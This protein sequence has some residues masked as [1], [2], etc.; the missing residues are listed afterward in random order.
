MISFLVALAVLIGGYFVY[1]LLV[2]RVF[3]IEPDRPTP[4]LTRTDGVDYVPMPGWKIFLVQFLNIAGLGPIFGAIMG[5]MYGPAAYLWIVLGTILAGGV[6]DFVSGMISL[7]AGGISLPEIVGRELGTGIKHVMRVFSIVL[8]ILVGGVF[9]V[10]TS[11][12]IASMT[13][14]SLDATFWATAI[15]IYYLLATLFP[16]DKLIGNIYPLFALVLFFMAVGLVGVMLFGDVEVPEAFAGGLGNRYAASMVATH[17][18][19]PMLFISIACGAISG[20]HA[21]QS[22]MMA[23]CMTN[24]RQGRPIFYGAMVAEGV[25]ALIWAA[26][27]ITFTGGYEGLS[28]YMAQPG[29]GPGT[30]I[31]EISNSWFGVVGGLIAMIGVIAAPITTGDTA[32]RSARL[33]VADFAHFGQCKF[34]QRVVVALPLFAL[35]FLLLQI[36]FNMLWRYFAWSN[37]TLAVFTLWACTVYL[38]RK[39]KFYV[40]TLIPA[41]FMTVV[42]T[43]YLLVAPSP[44]GFGLDQT[45]SVVAGCL[46][47]ALLAC[48]FF[49]WKRTETGGLKRT[50][51][52]I[53]RI[54]R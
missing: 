48:M 16:V 45:I 7:R 43:A 52:A 12:L 36:D 53:G 29:N 31:H 21:T 6:H 20:F 51:G 50:P 8:L 49:R 30:I 4:A 27:T 13:P 44:E 32:L 46:L 40:V 14:E 33:I 22:P 18:I 2:E 17:P 26:A 3:G 35:T 9:V 15:F 28:H 10:T 24:E 19:M 37:Q 23:R 39:C 34:W 11:G 1:G 41:L 47:A 54:E 5:I 42:C 25:V 38:A